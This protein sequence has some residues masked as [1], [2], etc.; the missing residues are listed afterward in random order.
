M[1]HMLPIR[2]IWHPRALA[3]WH[4]W[5]N[6]IWGKM[7]DS[8]ETQPRKPLAWGLY[9]G[10]GLAIFLPMAFFA[11]LVYMIYPPAFYPR[12]EFPGLEAQGDTL[13]PAIER[14]HSEHGV[15]P[16]TLEAAGVSTPK[17]RWGHWQYATL[18]D[19]TYQLSVGK[20]DRH[21]FTLYKLPGKDWYRDT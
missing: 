7:N 2:P 6:K 9:L 4:M 1:P 15:Y 10:A 3:F 14:Y 16:Q 8:R 5:L 13:I 19:G 21:G 18:P 11:G 20:Y 17:T 12:P